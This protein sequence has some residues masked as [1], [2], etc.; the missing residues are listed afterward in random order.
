M[1]INYPLLLALLGAVS[2]L[3]PLVGFLFAVAAALLVGLFQ[4]PILGLL[5][6]VFTIV[7]FIA[8]QILV[9]E[10]LLRLR[11][12]FSYLLVALLMIPL[13]DVYGFFGLLAA[14]PL[15]V[16]MESLAGAL[17]D[18]R[19]QQSLSG[20]RKTRLEELSRRL[21]DIQEKTSAS[22]E[23]LAP[24]LSN[25]VERLDTLLDRT[26]VALAEE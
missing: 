14:P 9:E 18:S 10:R 16:S 7:S 11:R 17:F 6:A 12:N 1:G 2:W 24:E 21:H 23:G 5:A 8:I 20:D 19:R 15:A 4:S 13:A 22:D 3:I 25:L 26:A